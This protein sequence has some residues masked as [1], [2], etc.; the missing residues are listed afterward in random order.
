MLITSCDATSMSARLPQGT[1]ATWTSEAPI[2]RLRPN[3]NVM[4]PSMRTERPRRTVSHDD[5]SS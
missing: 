1:F 5:S 4:S 2:W 3:S